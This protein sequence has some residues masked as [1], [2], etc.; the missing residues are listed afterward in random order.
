MKKRRIRVLVVRQRGPIR[1]REPGSFVVEAEMIRSEELRP[2]RLGPEEVD[3][4]DY[5]LPLGEERP[6]KTLD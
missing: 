3:L 4:V 5:S 2:D 6:A 1:R